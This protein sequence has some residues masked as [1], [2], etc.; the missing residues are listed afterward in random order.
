MSSYSTSKL[1]RRREG[2]DG[3]MDLRNPA[4]GKQTKGAANG[5]CFLALHGE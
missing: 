4:N 1:I 2:E 5:T 3:I